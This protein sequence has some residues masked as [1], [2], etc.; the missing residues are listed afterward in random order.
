MSENGTYQYLESRPESIYRQLYIKGT[1][2]QAELLYRATINAEEP[3]TAEELA[4]DYGLPL[5]VV[6]EAIAY[7]K[8]NPPEV[9]ADFAREERIMAATGMLDPDY[10]YHPQPKLLEPEEWDRLR[11]S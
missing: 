4:A 2:I 6:E 3:R 11:R 10:K 1:R 9:A 8:S 7:G 5:A